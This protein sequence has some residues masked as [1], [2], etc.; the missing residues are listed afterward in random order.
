MGPMGLSY[1]GSGSK[2]GLSTAA[3]QRKVQAPNHSPGLW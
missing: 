1:Q 2:A 3:T